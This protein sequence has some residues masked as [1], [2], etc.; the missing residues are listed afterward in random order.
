MSRPGESQSADPEKNSAQ[1]L[2][3][4]AGACVRSGHCCKQAPCPFG[5]WNEAKTQCAHL[6]G[7]RPGE[8]AC[9]VHDEIQGQPGA[10]LMPAFGAGCCSPLNTD[11]R[12]LH[13]KRTGSIDNEAWPR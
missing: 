5:E 1:F 9:G 4:S 11:R 12:V 6:E 2:S 3:Q 8:Y 10:D 13:L 7:D